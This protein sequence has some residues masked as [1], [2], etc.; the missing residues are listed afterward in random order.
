[1]LEFNRQKTG[2]NCLILFRKLHNAYLSQTVPIDKLLITLCMLVSGDFHPCPGPRPTAVKKRGKNIS[3]A[4]LPICPLWA[5]CTVK[6][7]SRAISCDGCDRWVHLA[8]SD[9]TRE[10]YDKMCRG[11]VKVDFYCNSCQISFLPN[12]EIENLTTFSKD[13]IRN[14]PADGQ[15]VEG[16]GPPWPERGLPPEPPNTTDDFDCFKKRGV[17]AIHLNNRSRLPKMFEIRLIANKTNAS[18][19]GKTESWLDNTVNDSEISIP[20]YCVV[21]HGGDRNGGGV[22]V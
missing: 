19:I 22:C 10:Q 5:R 7:N 17:H 2:F 16:E 9:I 8:C 20:G 12:A 4:W 1:M 13:S 21:R 18:I 6:S 15:S 14:A 3:Q 11:S